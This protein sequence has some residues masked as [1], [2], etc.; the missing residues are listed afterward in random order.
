MKVDP[1]EN[2]KLVNSLIASSI[3]Q[4][5]VN[6]LAAE[7]KAVNKLYLL[8]KDASERMGGP[9]SASG[10]RAIHL[11]RDNGSRK[12]VTSNSANIRKAR[13]FS[14]ASPTAISQHRIPMSKGAKQA[15]ALEERLNLKAQTGP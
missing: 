6:K 13:S 9:E 2:I 3:S 14:G 10:E 1:L 7:L 11:K 12:K 15:T 8:A 5:A 4:T